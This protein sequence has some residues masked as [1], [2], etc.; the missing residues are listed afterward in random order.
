MNNI[1][2]D[3]K[4]FISLASKPGNFGNRFHNFLYETYGVNAIYK[5]LSTDDIKNSIKAIKALQI[6]GCS[7]SM[8]FKR[9]STEFVDVLSDE[10]K[11]IGSLNT[12][13]NNDNILTGYNTDF[14]ACKEIV[15]N[16]IKTDDL[17]LVYGSG[18][19]AASICHA[20]YTLEIKN[21]T[22]VSR[23]MQTGKTLANKYSFLYLNEFPNN[24]SYNVLINSTPIGMPGEHETTCVFPEKLIKHTQLIWDVVINKDVTPLINK[25]KK[26]K[27]KSIDG[28]NTTLLQAKEQ[29]YR[30]TGIRPADTDVQNAYNYAIENL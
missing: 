2:K 22:L 16:N 20:L 24:I 4:L 25:S 18:G 26:L 23:N 7:V 13:V 19:M 5:S 8:P 28:S 6:A 30:Y 10:V 27:I 9:I 11:S 17:V 3:T 15:K 1:N 14:L 29:F 21:V 12:I